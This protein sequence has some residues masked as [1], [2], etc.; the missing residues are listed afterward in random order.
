MFRILSSFVTL[1]LC[2]KLKNAM[3]SM[4]GIFRIN[5]SPL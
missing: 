4:D 3:V 5:D 1:V 2:E